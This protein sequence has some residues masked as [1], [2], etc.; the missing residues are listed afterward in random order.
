MEWLRISSILELNA[1]TQN[2][3]IVLIHWKYI[4]NAILY[5]VNWFMCW[6][7]GFNL[8]E[9]SQYHR[10]IVIVGDKKKMLL[11]DGIFSNQ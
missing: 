8:N 5:V 2:G 3:D 7:F 10:R 4:S 9:M 1:M 11:C 6:Y